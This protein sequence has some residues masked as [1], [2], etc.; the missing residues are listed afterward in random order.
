MKNTGRNKE[1]VDNQWKEGE[2]GNPKGRPKGRRNFDT[3]F[4]EAIRKIA[5]E[6]KLNIDDPEKQM[7]VKAVVEAL[8]GNFNFYRD[9]MD[10]KYGK[11]DQNLDVNGE[12]TVIVKRGDTLDASSESRK[13]S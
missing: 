2:S 5:E 12:L 11:P 10:R 4:D 3:I 7:V 9:I 8:K 1:F 13:D 6:K